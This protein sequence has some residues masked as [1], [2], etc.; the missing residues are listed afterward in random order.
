MNLLNEIIQA[1]RIK[2]N[3]TEEQKILADK[4]LTI[5]KECPSMKVKFEDSGLI[6]ITVCDE[7]G[8]PIAAKIHSPKVGACPLGKWDEVDGKK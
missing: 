4:R 8:C 7:C 6:R 1:W 3:P 2:W 5:C